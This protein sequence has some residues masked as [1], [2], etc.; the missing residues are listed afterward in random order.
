MENIGKTFGRF[1]IKDYFV[2]NSRQYYLCE[3]SYNKDKESLS[4]VNL[5]AI[6]DI[7]IVD[8]IST[9]VLMFYRFFKT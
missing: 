5:K 6:E 3:C 2:K 1:T 8:N 4:I 9:I 7:E